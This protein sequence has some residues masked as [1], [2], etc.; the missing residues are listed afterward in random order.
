MEKNKIIKAIQELDNW[1][2]IYV[3]EELSKGYSE[4]FLEQE[5][6]IDKYTIGNM[7]KVLI[8]LV[9]E[10]LVECALLVK[11][12]NEAEENARM[13]QAGIETLLISLG[14][15]TLWKKIAQKIRNKKKNDALQQI[16]NEFVDE[17]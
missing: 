8:E 11:H 9:Q 1:E 4:D 5:I 14:V 16:L 2:L 10:D 15:R 7:R 6:K 17:D 12:I 13:G 3:L